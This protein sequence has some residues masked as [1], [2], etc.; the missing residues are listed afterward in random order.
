MRAERGAATVWAA[1]IVAGLL[2]LGLIGLQIAQLVGLR[3]QASAGADLAALAA[4]RASLAGQAGCE[5]ADVVARDNG[6]R[7]VRCRMD[8]DV[9]T[10]T[11]R[12]ES[13]RW[14]GG[15]WAVEQRARAAPVSYLPP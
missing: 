4:S 5:R 2:V 15:R 14:W 9:A 8:A 12:A 1:F 7:L 13:A 3:H 11:A 10:V 6:T